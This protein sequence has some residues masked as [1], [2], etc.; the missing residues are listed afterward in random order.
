[1]DQSGGG[2]VG[3]QSYG[4]GSGYDA[5]YLEGSGAG[6]GAGGVDWSCLGN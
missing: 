1:M 3:F 6:D 5:V 2:D 4:A